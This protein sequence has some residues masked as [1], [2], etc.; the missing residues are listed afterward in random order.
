MRNWLAV[1]ILA[2]LFGCHS[3]DSPKQETQ[4][5]SYEVQL[6]TTPYDLRPGGPGKAYS[7]QVVQ[8]PGNQ[9]VDFSTWPTGTW[10]WELLNVPAGVDG[11]RFAAF[12]SGHFS[13]IVFPPDFPSMKTTLSQVY[14]PPAAL[15]PG[16]TRLEMKVRI[17]ITP[18]GSL[19]GGPVAQA[20]SPIAVDVNAPTLAP[21]KGDAQEGI[22]VDAHPILR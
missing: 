13:D 17:T 11:G 1:P 6:H 9:I 3:G 22:S 4:P 7:L 20:E 18:P 12:A 21:P 8:Q 19:N 16:V 2:I 14:Y 15:P 10:R 5:L